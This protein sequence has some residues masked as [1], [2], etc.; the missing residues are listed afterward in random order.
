[1]HILKVIVRDKAV[2]SNRLPLLTLFGRRRMEW[3]DRYIFKLLNSKLIYSACE[4][5]PL[6][7]SSHGKCPKHRQMHLNE[8]SLT[9]AEFCTLLFFPTFYNTGVKVNV[10][11]MLY[12]MIAL[13]K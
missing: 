5:L 4:I 3:G 11:A 1:M 8:I 6:F 13:S 12:D 7:S 9:K 2:Y 10:T